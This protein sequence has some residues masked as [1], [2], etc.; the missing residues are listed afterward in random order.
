[1]STARLLGA[2][3]AAYQPFCSASG[4]CGQPPYFFVSGKVLRQ[5]EKSITYVSKQH[6]LL[7]YIP[8]NYG[9]ITKDYFGKQIM[10]N[11]GV[12]CVCDILWESIV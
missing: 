1:M 2:A 7:L 9:E 5:Q 10:Y 4:L 3:S 6:D 8:Y 11:D 12:S